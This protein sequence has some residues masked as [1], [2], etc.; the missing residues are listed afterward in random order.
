MK[1]TRFL[2]I[3]AFLY[4]FIPSAFAQ[5]GGDGQIQPEC[6][7]G[8]TPVTDY[9]D[10]CPVKGQ[11]CT[12]CDYC[13]NNFI[14]PPEECDTDS[15][16]VDA[17][18]GARCVNC[19]LEW[20]GDGIVNGDEVCDPT[21]PESTNAGCNVECTGYGDCQDGYQLVCDYSCED[22]YGNPIWC[23]SCPSCG[24]G[25]LNGNEE[26]DGEEFLET[27]PDN[28]RACNQATCKASYCG[29]GV[30]DTTREV[31]DIGI[32]PGEDGY[33]EDCNVD[34]KKT[35]DNFYVNINHEQVG[36]GSIFTGEG[37][38]LSCL[39]NILNICNS[40]GSNTS[41]ATYASADF[42]YKTPG[43]ADDCV[44]SY[45]TSQ[46]EG[47]TRED[48]YQLMN[49]MYEDKFEVFSDWV[50]NL[51]NNVP[52][53]YV[54]HIQKIKNCESFDIYTG[55]EDLGSC[56][57]SYDYIY[58]I[59]GGER[60]IIR[61]KSR[62]DIFIESLSEYLGECTGFVTQQASKFTM[63]FS[64]HN[65][66]FMINFYC[67][68]IPEWV[69][70]FIYNV[71]D[72]YKSKPIVMDTVFIDS[73]CNFIS[74]EQAGEM[75]GELNVNWMYTPI[76]LIFD[77]SVDLNREIKLT[78]FPLEIG[79]KDKWYTWKASDKAPLLVYDPE[80]KGKIESAKNLFGQWAFGGK[81]NIKNYKISL[82]SERLNPEPWKD[83][84]E[85]LASLDINNDKKLTENELKDIYLWFDTNSNGISEDGE[86]RTLE[87]VGVLSISVTYDKVDKVTGDKIAL[88]GYERKIGERIFTGKSVDWYA[89][90]YNSEA[91]AV[92]E[93][94]AFSEEIN[95]DKFKVK[96]SQ[97]EYTYTP[98]KFNQKTNISGGWIWKVEKKKGAPDL[99]GGLLTFN[100]SALGITGKS[101]IQVPLKR[102][103]RKASGVLKMLPLIGEKEL[104][105]SEPIIKFKVISDN[106]T[107][108][109][110]EA[111]L[112][113]DGKTLNGK[114]FAK[115][116]V[117]DQADP[118]DISY[119][120]VAERYNKKS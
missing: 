102:K 27:I 113:A 52:S 54:E 10:F 31:C 82:K 91:D 76:S 20:C 2:L 49:S 89:K 51:E 88:S 104:N 69:R 105:N 120:W 60:T 23:C 44:A 83:G 8:Q 81:Q 118:I 12:L 62:F 4:V 30:I 48:M 97:T 25:I 98:A 100:D 46:G 3:F 7:L 18:N 92:N 75:C 90:S 93:S 35:C 16:P 55:N 64:D 111:K 40:D 21:A 59:S 103:D 77:D 96:I 79:Q 101:V 22:T 114:T 78:Q 84:F 108:T 29:D 115:I 9:F 70:N 110:S 43:Y 34:C 57:Y 50:V 61:K 53:E 63:N 94:F 65:I 6:P 42:A 107:E 109:K 32:L 24:D 73:Q 37:A 47:G 5:T 19:V 66:N 33:D 14:S 74:Q 38:Q 72:V 116:K 1:S 15:I 11:L 112:S 45:F 68:D 85:A 117:S 13:G 58:T 71:I 67:P 26:C 41:T 36:Q 99:P 119:T 80:G 39:E 28:L 17:P 95:S 87:N 86:V 106:G 56:S